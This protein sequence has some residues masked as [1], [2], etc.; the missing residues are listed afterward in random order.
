METEPK[1]LWKPRDIII[2]NI[3]TTRYFSIAES[4]TNNLKKNKPIERI[5]EITPNKLQIISEITDNYAKREEIR[6]PTQR[7]VV[8]LIILLRRA[9]QLAKDGGSM[10]PNTFIG[11]IYTEDYSVDPSEISLN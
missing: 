7:E 10:G 1:N 6:L 2:P 5:K 9:I 11:R 8:R 3:Y 4:Y